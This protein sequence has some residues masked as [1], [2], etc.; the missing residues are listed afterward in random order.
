MEP[1]PEWVAERSGERTELSE[2]LKEQ[3]LEDLLPHPNPIL[4]PYAAGIPGELRMFYLPPRFYEWSGPLVAKMEN[5]I[6]Y[7][8][9]YLDPITGA[10]HEIGTA[11]GDENGCWQAPEVPIM[12]DWVLALSALL[13]S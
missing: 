4:Q 5:G 7:H 2:S 8:A 9:R 6:E 11:V 3:G 13:P 12:Q 1:H 10:E